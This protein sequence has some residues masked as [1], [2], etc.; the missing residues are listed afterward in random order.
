MATR[1][2]GT[3]SRQDRSQP[4]SAG[5]AARERKRRAKTTR[6]R[7]V[8]AGVLVIIAAWA[9]LYFFPVLT[10]KNVD[11]QGAQHADAQQITQASEVG[12][13]SNMLRLDTEEIAR[14]VAPTPWVKKVTVSRSWPSTVNISVEEHEAVGVVKKDGETS[15]VNR[16][17]KVFLNGPAPKGAVE[18][19][20]V[21]DGDT[22]ALAAAAKAVDA[23]DPEN[24]K[25]LVQVAAPNAEAIEMTFELPAPKGED[26][27][28]RKVVYLG[29]AEKL[30]EKAEAVRVVL[31]R[32]QPNWNVSNPAM[33]TARD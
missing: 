26:K 23:L 30:A 4:R 18:F 15:L 3:R 24:R 14:K 13:R 1:A 12:E 20:E 21:K 19:T 11:V 5:A 17:G 27:G 6:R 9:V 32:E 28:P 29:S 8:A 7:W 31:Q 16:D 22:R 10:V 2:E 33:P 25:H